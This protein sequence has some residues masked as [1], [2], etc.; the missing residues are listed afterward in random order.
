M[1]SNLKQF[2][3]DEFADLATCLSLN[4]SFSER[5]PLSVSKSNAQ[6]HFSNKFETKKATDLRFSDSE[7]RRNLP[8]FD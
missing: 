2:I 3:Y 6:S 1:L 7:S 5:M 8:Q 4:F